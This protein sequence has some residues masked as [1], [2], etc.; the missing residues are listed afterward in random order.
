MRVIT[1]AGVTAG[2]HT[3]FSAGLADVGDDPEC[4]GA[5]AVISL[6]GW[7]PQ[8]LCDPYVSPIAEFGKPILTIGVIFN[9]ES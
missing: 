4:F 9:A 3:A 2:Q 6:P 5:A 8:R 7:S 1:C